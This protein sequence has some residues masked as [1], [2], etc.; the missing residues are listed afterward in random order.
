MADVITRETGAQAKG[1]PLTNAELDQ[2]FINLDSDKAEK[3]EVQSGI[4][5]A[6]SHA[7]AMAIVFGG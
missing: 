2:N 1:A 6:K 5:S 3:T 7:V 4:D